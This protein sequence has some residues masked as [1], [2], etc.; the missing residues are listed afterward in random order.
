MRASSMA[1]GGR[2][3]GRRSRPPISRNR[4]RPR[5]TR[6]A[7]FG[8]RWPGPWSSR[9]GIPRGRWSKPQGWAGRTCECS[10]GSTVPKR[11]SSVTSRWRLQGRSTAALSTR[12]ARRYRAQWCARWVAQRPAHRRSKRYAGSGGAPSPIWDGADPGLK[13]PRTEA[14]TLPK[15]PRARC[16]WLP[17]AA[18]ST[19]ATPRRSTCRMGGPPKHP[20]SS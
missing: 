13:R 15:L 1:E 17:A 11:L 6:R 5:R 4:C 3:R 10:G 20:T 19:S 18:E 12:R 2:S 9:K 14:T 8:S 7:T 16:R